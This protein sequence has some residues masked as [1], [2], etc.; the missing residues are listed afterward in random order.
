MHGNSKKI[1]MQGN[2]DCTSL[3]VD[4]FCADYPLVAQYGLSIS[5]QSFGIQIG[6][7][8][9]MLHNSVHILVEPDGIK[10]HMTC[11]FL[12]FANECILALMVEDFGLSPGNCDC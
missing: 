12:S 1:F 5:I 11:T 9:M 2:I 3:C 10:H 6:A 4:M 7:N 8:I